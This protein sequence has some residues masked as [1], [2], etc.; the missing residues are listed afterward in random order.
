M[1]SGR[2]VCGL[3]KKKSQNQKN[4]KCKPSLR[5]GLLLVTPGGWGCGATRPQL[6][7]ARLDLS[8]VMEVVVMVDFIS[9]SFII[10]C[11]SFPFFF[12]PLVKKRTLLKP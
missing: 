8:G 5:E 7:V 6:G 4:T 11:S 3:K 2:G 10:F 9:L 1:A 12:P